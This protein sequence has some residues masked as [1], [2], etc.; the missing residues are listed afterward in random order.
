LQAVQNCHLSIVKLLVDKG[1]ILMDEYLFD[2]KI[3][4]PT[5]IQFNIIKYLLKRGANPKA[6]DDSGHT[7]LHQQCEKRNLKNVKYLIQHYNADVKTKNHRGQTP[8]HLA[9]QKEENLEMIKFLIEEKHADSTDTCNEGKTALHYAAES[10]NPIILRYL[11]EVHQKLDIEATDNQGRTALHIACESNKLFDYRWKTQKYLI[12][13]NSK[14]IDATDKR[15]KSA[16]CY[17]LNNFEKKQKYSFVDFRPIALILATKAKTWQ[18]KKKKETD[19]IFNWIKQSYNNVLRKKNG[20][21]QAVLCVIA[22]LKSFQRD[23]NKRF[24]KP[25]GY[26]PL[27]HIVGFCNRVDI[28]EYMFSRDLCYF[29]KHFNDGEANSRRKLLLKSY[30]EFSCEKGFLDLTRFLFQE[31]NNRQES[32][33]HL[34]FDGSFLE[35]ACTNKHF[36]VF[37]Y[38][39]EDDKAKDE[40]AKFLQDFPLH[41]ACENG[42]LDI[43]QHLTETK[44]IYIEAKDKEGRTPL[45]LACRA[46]SIEIAQYLIEKQNA[47]VNTTDNEGRSVLH[48]ACR[49]G[50][51][52][53]AQY[54][55]EKQNA[56][57][58]T[59]DNKGS[60]VLHVER[61]KGS[62]G[63]AKYLIDK[64]N[65]KIHPTD[66]KGI[67]AWHFACNSGSL[68]LVKY[69]SQKTKQDVNAQ[70]EDGSTALHMACKRRW[71]NLKL[72]KF[73]ITDMKADLK[74]VDKEGKT[75]LHVACQSRWPNVQI[76]KL[77]VYHG[78]NV[79]AKDKSGKSPMQ[80]A[81]SKLSPR[82][83]LSSVDQVTFLK[84]AVKR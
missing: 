35:T 61:I 5:E 70:D 53:I 83:L 23:L 79:L 38:L 52:E 20:E 81:S 3:M 75:P 58:N 82:S 22:G 6:T 42:S 45:H 19:F 62:I 14:I 49:A 31:I 78:A 72:V 84:A 26:N 50:S 12:E 9:C 1:A 71:P 32:F 46:G 77:L 43:V 69:I 60:S 28:A 65:A 10:R 67:S 73:I 11:I 39:L 4:I 21:A 51:I 55:I 47:N 25:S 68:E 7:L 36:N 29:D 66:N 33:R 13:E 2:K 57:A 24:E 27:L 41:C 34:R 44:Q 15:G 63:V 76:A 30:L 54:L 17:C 37:K 80:I 18:K 16:L 74:I 59:T 8:L 40:A 48:L 56:N 64:N